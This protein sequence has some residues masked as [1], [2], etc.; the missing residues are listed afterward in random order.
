MTIFYLMENVFCRSI[1]SLKRV[2][3]M[4]LN[5]VQAGE[6]QGKL[7]IPLTPMLMSL[8]VFSF[9]GF[10]LVRPHLLGINHEN[11]ND[12]EGFVHFWAVI[13]YMLGIKDE[14]N[15]C[16]HPIEVVEM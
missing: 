2:R 5:A 15:M 14:F 12:R 11:Q 6:R 4:H 7:R 3:G 10:A 16:L 9:M 1:K 13:G 8:T